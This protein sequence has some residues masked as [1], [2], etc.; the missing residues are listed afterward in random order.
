[1]SGCFAFSN[2]PKGQYLAGP[3]RFDNVLCIA[4]GADSKLFADVVEK[5]HPPKEGAEGCEA[6]TSRSLRR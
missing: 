4:Y 1:M 5:G 2:C 3:Q 6:S